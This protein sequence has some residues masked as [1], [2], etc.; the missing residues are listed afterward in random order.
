PRAARPA[1]RRRPGHR[2]EDRRL[3][4]GPRRLSLRGRARPGAGHRREEAR[5]AQGPAPGVRA[6]AAA[7]WRTVSDHPRHLLLGA[8]VAGLLAG[9]VARELAA[10][11]A[12]LAGLALLRRPGLAL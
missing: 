2:A 4:P 11:V 7:A 9:P 3:P 10:A 5:R 8:L 1:R 12:A 6:S